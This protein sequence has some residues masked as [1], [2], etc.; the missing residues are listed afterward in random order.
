MA[1]NKQDSETGASVRTFGYR[2]SPLLAFILI[3]GGVLVGYAAGIMQMSKILDIDIL[4]PNKIKQLDNP[5]SLTQEAATVPPTMGIGP[6]VGEVDA[7]IT[8]VEFTDYQCSL[9]TRFY[10]DSYARIY[11]NYIK[12]G[13]VKFEIRN[14][15]LSTIHPAAQI[16]SEAALCAFRQD[17]FWPM[18]EKLLGDTAWSEAEDPV[19]A[20]KKFARTLKLETDAFG[21]CL[22]LHET[23][24][25][26]QKDME[27]ALRAGINGSPTFWIFGPDKQVQ[28]I[29]GAY[30]YAVFE[31]TFEEFLKTESL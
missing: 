29:N 13:K 18:Y 1:S 16:G 5:I 22:D 8:V 12:P 15:P 27:E 24:A 21:R 20:L 3:T 6:S 25:D 31:R 26:L 10:T 17:K 14:Y 4:K 9:C 28:Q 19:P 30:P 23:Q 7:P 11:K 2:V